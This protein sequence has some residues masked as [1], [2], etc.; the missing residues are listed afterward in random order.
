MRGCGN[1]LGAEQSGNIASVGLDMYAELMQEAVDALRG[2]ATELKIEAE[3]NLPL[4]A[5]LP[6]DY[7]TDVQMRLLFYKRLANAETIEQ[8]YEI[9]GELSDR[10]G[11]APKEAHSLKDTF[12]LKIM[13]AELGIRQMDANFTS[14]ILDLGDNSKLDPAKLVSLMTMHP[15]QYTIRQ[16]QKLIRYLTKSES[17]ALTETAALYLDE[18]KSRCFG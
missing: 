8:L 13:L 11:P 16:D 6:E 12:E 4:S 10:Y 17:E 2:E 5:Y 1:L 7:I 14:I 15:R 9:F 18:L 3:V